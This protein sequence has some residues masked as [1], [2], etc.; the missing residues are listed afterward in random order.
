[1]RNTLVMFTVVIGFGRPPLAPVPST[2]KT[3]FSI[4]SSWPATGAE[5]MTRFSL[6]SIMM[7]ALSLADAAVSPFWATPSTP[8]RIIEANSSAVILAG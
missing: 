6:A 8:S 1:M 7:R 3:K 4:I 5:A 2:C